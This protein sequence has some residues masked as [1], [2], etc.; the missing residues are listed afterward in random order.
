MATFYDTVSIRLT[1]DDT[2]LR[3]QLA[4][5]RAQVDGLVAGKA[6]IIPGSTMTTAA[7]GARS[8]G[9]QATANAG[10]FYTAGEALTRNIRVANAAGSISAPVIAGLATE[11]SQEAFTLAARA[12]TQQAISYSFQGAAFNPAATVAPPI[13]TPPPVVTP[14]SPGTPTPGAPGPGVGG[15]GIYTNPASYTRKAPTIPTP[16]NAPTARWGTLMKLGGPAGSAVK[17]VAQ[18]FKSPGAATAAG[19]G[20]VFLATRSHG[21]YRREYFRTMM[22]TPGAPPEFKPFSHM[23]ESAVESLHDALKAG[24][25]LLIDFGALAVDA[26]LAMPGPLGAVV[27]MFGDDNTRARWATAFTLAAQDYRERAGLNIDEIREAGKRSMRKVDEFVAM[28]KAAQESAARVG[29]AALQKA[30]ELGI[31]GISSMDFVRVFAKNEGLVT[32]IHRES[33]AEKEKREREAKKDYEVTPEDVL[34][35]FG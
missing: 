25:E 31:G 10:V 1:A 15:P 22:T 30:K 28:R 26:G 20:A 18:V 23:F 11:T 17:K 4:A 34:K 12:R 16:T 33:I 21:Q 27:K 24:G 8:F 14:P 32:R 9:A 2:E 29:I 7:R 19:V 5:W 6:S 35:S 13:V 3:A